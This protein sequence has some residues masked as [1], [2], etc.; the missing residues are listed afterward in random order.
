MTPAQLALEIT[1]ASVAAPLAAI[2]GYCAQ[3]IV[4]ARPG[5][6][7]CCGA[8]RAAAYD[9]E[10]PRLAAP[11]ELGRRRDGTIQARI[12]TL[13]ADGRQRTA[14]EMAYEL[15]EG[16]DTVAREA[17]KLARRQPRLHRVA[18]GGHERAVWFLR[19]A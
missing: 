7:Y 17:R 18:R 11:I 2:C 12:E 19:A 1:P 10:H 13:L 16:A 3:A 6:R 4:H 5:Q 14:A 15:R 9:A 8:C